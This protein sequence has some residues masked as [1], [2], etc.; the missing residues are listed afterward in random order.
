MFPAYLKELCVHVVLVGSRVTCNPPP[1]DTDQDVLCLID[2][3]NLD[4]LL[5]ALEQDGFQFDGS[6]HYANSLEEGEGFRS[7]RNGEINLVMTTE[8][9]FYHRFMAAT[10]IAKHLN[11]LKKDDRIALFQAVLYG[12]EYVSPEPAALGIAA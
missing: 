8:F 5:Q 7:Y 10:S 2:D 6:E 1:T 3:S 4:K 9:D 11:L 12:N